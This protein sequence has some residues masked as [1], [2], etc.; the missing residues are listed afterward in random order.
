MASS[1]AV[2]GTQLQRTPRCLQ[3]AAARQG[4]QRPAVTL[5]AVADRGSSGGAVLDRP[6]LDRTGLST[7]PQ[8]DSSGSQLGT[9]GGRGTGGG[10]WRILLLDSEH[11]TEERVVQ[12]ILAVVPGVEEP[13]A[14]N[15]FH[16][17][18]GCTACSAGSACQSGVA[19]VARKLPPLPHIIP[20][21]QLPGV[22]VHGSCTQDS[23]L[24]VAWSITVLK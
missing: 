19:A 12:A 9:S 13:H 5:A 22:M 1:S 16:K 14:A 6:G 21:R 4:R 3:A 24:A 17:V 2:V 10:S 20:P 11:H 18:R 7:A 8:T 15:C 23:I